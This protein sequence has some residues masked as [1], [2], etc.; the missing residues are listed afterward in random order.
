MG[1]KT[2]SERWR[3]FLLQSMSP[4]CLVHG[5]RLASPDWLWGRAPGEQLH[6]SFLDLTAVSHKATSFSALS[7]SS[8]GSAHRPVLESKLASPSSC[9]YG[10]RPI[11]GGWC[12][13]WIKLLFDEHLQCWDVNTHHSLSLHS[14]K[15]SGYWERWSSNW[16]KNCK[17]CS[18]MSISAEWGCFWRMMV[19]HTSSCLGFQQQSL[20]PTGAANSPAQEVWLWKYTYQI[21]TSFLG[22][23]CNPEEWCCYWITACT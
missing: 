10:N 9:Y 22:K 5:T 15:N 19:A 16:I 7:L 3:S 11:S 8:R 23:V 20:A 1:L 2:V 18:S 14:Y 21:S 13:A 12:P 4:V 17:I 6:T